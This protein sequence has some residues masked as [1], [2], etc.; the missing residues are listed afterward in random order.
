MILRLTK[1]KKKI[2]KV[3][4][5]KQ[6]YYKNIIHKNLMIFIL[7]HKISLFYYVN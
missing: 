6:L 3:S 2:M 4:D 1:I 5:I 7:Y